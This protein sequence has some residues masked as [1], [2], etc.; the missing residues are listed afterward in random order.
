MTKSIL[1][2]NEV[3]DRARKILRRQGSRITFPIIK[4]VRA[5]LL[6]EWEWCYFDE[7]MAR[8]AEAERL[9][10]QNEIYREA[11]NYAG[12]K[13]C[14]KSEVAELNAILKKSRCAVQR[15]DWRNTS[16]RRKDTRP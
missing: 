9:E 12:G 10:K 7:F 3:P 11:L 4:C 5:C 13:L 2:N 16:Q 8:D 14:S 6:E 1:H 15:V